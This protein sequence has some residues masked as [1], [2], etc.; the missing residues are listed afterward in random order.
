[1]AACCV[2]FRYAEDF[3]EEE[4]LDL[5]SPGKYGVPAVLLGTAYMAIAGAPQSRNHANH[6]INHAVTQPR[7]PRK[8]P[9]QPRN[10]AISTTRV[11]KT[12]CNQKSCL[13]ACLLIQFQ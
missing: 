5:F 7:K 11:F 2:H 3:P 10:H 9:N 8:P 1:M 12:W 6:P 4:P 13:P